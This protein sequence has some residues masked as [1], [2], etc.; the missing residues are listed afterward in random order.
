MR[1]KELLHSKKNENQPGQVNKP[2]RIAGVQGF[3]GDSPFGAMAIVNENAA[4]YLVHDALAELTLSILQKD[5]LK[6]PNLGYARDI[7]I[8][9]N[10]LYPTA[11]KKGIKIVTNSGGLNPVNAAKK[12]AELLSK[13]GISGVKIA[14]ITGDDMSGR[15]NELQNKGEKLEHLESDAALN[16]T[17]NTTH[18]NVYV[19][20]QCI[21]DALSQGADIILAGRVADPCLTLGILAHHF[22][23]NIDNGNLDLLAAGITVGHVLECGGQASGG[24]AYS[25]WPM[26]YGLSN[27]G[28]PIAHVYEDGKAEFTKLKSQGG[29]VS[30]NTIREQLVYEIHD[31]SNYITPDVTVDLTKIKLEEI[32]EN[33]VRLNGVKGKSRPE[34]LKLAIGQMQGY[35]SD[36]FFFF[37]WPYAYEKAQKFIH[38][39]KEI[40]AK[41]PVNIERQEFQLIGVNG[42]H[43]DAAPTPSEEELDKMNEIGIRIAIQHKDKQT[44][45]MAMQSIIGLGLNGPP[46]VVGIPGW[47]KPNRI[48]LGLWPTLID[49]KH[50]EMKVEIIKS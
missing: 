3:Y 42:I 30:R 48:Q 16:S 43:G 24:N 27:L 2:I 40:W 1:W 12:T 25:E 15:L 39:T 28:Y 35:M 41:L 34:K 7:E 33:K 17:E 8:L 6:D 23:W 36:Q 13:Q 31:P 47:G 29:K 5:K 50:V 4:D 46:G 22:G 10:I 49:R 32:A 11:L 18:A 9:A 44:G 21:A 37:S 20:A 45:R 38:A 26:N 14:A 19:G